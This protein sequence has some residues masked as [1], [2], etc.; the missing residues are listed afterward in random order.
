VGLIDLFD[1][2]MIVNLPN[3]SDRRK[4]MRR[5]LVRVGWDPEDPRI[6]WFPAVDTQ[7]AAGYASPGARGCF[8][9][10]LAALNLARNAGHRRVLVLEDDCDFAPD[11]VERQAQVADWLASSPWGIA[12]L[13]HAEAVSGQPRL[14]RWPAETKVML[15]HCYAVAGDVLLRLPRYLEAITLRAPGSPDGGPMYSDAGVAWFRR[16]NPDVVTVLAVPSLAHQRSSRSDL[17]PRWF[18]KVPG[19]SAVAA[20]ARGIRRSDRNP[21]ARQA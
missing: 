19:L 18:D 3:R 14:V 13:G 6:V 4:Q 8:L 10:H 11:F 15:L 5:E 20:I 21:A 2:V 17:S 7:T 12:Y 1:C 9:S 16:H